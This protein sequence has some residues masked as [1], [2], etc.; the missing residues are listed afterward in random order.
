M[1]QYL[2]RDWIDQANTALSSTPSIAAATQGQSAC[3]QQE[4]AGGPLGDVTL[5]L[6]FDD[7]TVSFAEGPAEAADVTVRTDYETSAAMNRGEQNQ[8]AAFMA[9]K[10]KAEG[11]LM[12]V[13]SLQGAQ[14]AIDE[15]LTQ[16]DTTY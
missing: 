4:I 3:I 7:G 8:M 15:A 10:V 14:G 16:V 6:R 13:M 9:G 5:H 11:N 12:K 1:P 2:T